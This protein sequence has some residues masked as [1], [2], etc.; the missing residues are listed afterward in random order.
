MMTSLLSILVSFGFV[1]APP[2]TGYLS[3]QQQYTLLQYLGPAAR[4]LVPTA[5]KRTTETDARYAATWLAAQR[6]QPLA[7]YSLDST[8]ANAFQKD[9]ATLEALF[10][11]AANR[12]TVLYFEDG[13][14]LFGPR[15]TTPAH[16]NLKVAFLQ[17]AKN[18]RVAVV[19]QCISDESWYELADARWGIV[20]LKL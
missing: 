16:K 12:G 15:A 10:D 17:A 18:T 20:D 6:K 13:D 5:I 9:A 4:P 1:F 8:Q 7:V 3:P 14:W 19:V 2:Q 11:T